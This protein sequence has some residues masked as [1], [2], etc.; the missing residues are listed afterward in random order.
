LYIE[1]AAV[2]S[3]IRARCPEIGQIGPV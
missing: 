3:G 2:S 1:L